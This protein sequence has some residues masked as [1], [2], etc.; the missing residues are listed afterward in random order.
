VKESQLLNGHQNQGRAARKRQKKSASLVQSS[1]KALGTATINVYLWHPDSETLA[2]DFRIRTKDSKESNIKRILALFGIT[3]AN[4]F[5]QDDGSLVPNVRWVKDGSTL[6]VAPSLEEYAPYRFT[7]YAGE[8]IPGI[9]EPL[10]G[11]ALWTKY[12]ESERWYHIGALTRDFPETCKY[13][14]IT[15]P[16]LS[17]KRN[18][19]AVRNAAAMQLETNYAQEASKE[20]I[21]RNWG[22]HFALFFP[23]SLRPP[24]A[25][26]QYRADAKMLALLAILAKAMPGQNRLVKEILVDLEGA[27]GC[28]GVVNETWVIKAMDLIYRNAGL[29]VGSGILV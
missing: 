4:L 7:F 22:V 8:E 18:V 1:T 12:S 13:M 2:N 16:Y 3:S 15:E 20:K 26:G 5:T 19:E 11:Q 14:R 6:A 9:A 17:T 23:E 25:M 28:Y 27:D 29:V 10:Q 24:V 21:Y